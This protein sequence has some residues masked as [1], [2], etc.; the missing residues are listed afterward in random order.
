MTAETKYGQIRGGHNG[1]S[2][3]M[4]ANETFYSKSGRFVV[5]DGFGNGELADENDT[6]LQGFVRE[7]QPADGSGA[8]GFTTHATN[9]GDSVFWCVIDLTAVF[10]LPLAFS[11]TYDRNYSYALDGELCDIIVINGV[12]YV[13]LSQSNK[14]NVRIVGGKAASA[15]FTDGGVEGLCLGDGYVDVMLVEGKIYAQEIE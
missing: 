7:G 2:L 12:Q 3:H 14:D 5:N 8:G 6:N 4:G 9:E 10:R 13:D 15:I 11:A 1:F